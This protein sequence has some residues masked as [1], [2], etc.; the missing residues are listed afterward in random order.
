MDVCFF[1]SPCR[2]VKTWYE[3]TK[4]EL[5]VKHRNRFLRLPASNNY[6]TFTERKCKFVHQNGKSDTLGR[7]GLVKRRQP[8]L[9]LYLV[10]LILV[11]ASTLFHSYTF[12]QPYQ[13][14]F[15]E[16]VRLIASGKGSIVSSKITDLRCKIPETAGLVYIEGLLASDDREAIQYFHVVTDSFP[17]SEWADDALARLFELYMDQGQRG[18]ALDEMERLRS[19]YPNSP[20][21]TTN[22]LAQS[23]LASVSDS[24]PTDVHISGKEFAVQVGAF[25]IRANAD[26]LR[27]QFMLDGYRTDIYENL[28]DGRNLLYLVWIGS[29]KTREEADRTLAEIKS[30]Y[31]IDGI[32]RTRSS[33]KKW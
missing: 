5:N 6:L 33:W 31:N 32:L 22:Y 3:Y 11:C 23:S 17:R 12:A 1:L 13:K 4:F 26:K 9:D 18:T 7:I 8:R 21:V 30:K 14:K 24:I 20:Y 19:Q 10:G 28:L 16:Y 27:Q 25:S 29:F 2:Q 15:F